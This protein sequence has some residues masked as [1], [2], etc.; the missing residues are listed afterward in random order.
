[1]FP[2]AV[3]IAGAPAQAADWPALVDALVADADLAARQARLTEALLASAADPDGAAR[4]ASATR[5]V[6]AL[7][8]TER[9]DR[10]VVRAFLVAALG[11]D[12]AVRA[13]AVEQAT[14]GGDPP[15]MVALPMP[16]AVPVVAPAPPPESDPVALRAYA[17]DRLFRDRLDMSYTDV[18]IAQGA[19]WANDI[20]VNTW[21]V[22]D[23]G[24]NLYGARGFAQKVGDGA[25]LVGLHRR[26]HK[27]LGGSWASIAGGAA[28]STTGFVLMSTSARSPNFEG[29]LYG[30]ATAAIVGSIPLAVG[31]AFLQ[32]ELRFGDLVSRRYDED[33]TDAWI[34]RYNR[35]LQLKL[36]LSDA[37]ALDI[38]L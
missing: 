22:Y 15:G 34:E 30:G 6:L 18:Y 14:A 2:L 20:H 37:D 33:A 7:A 24:G 5:V 38:D 27:V 9:S 13:Q 8:E 23:G 4:V 31:L 26:R 12:P 11:D 25:G 19:A 17:K 3:L 21:G 28:V 16:L 36:G 35:A 32:K 1:M 29:R 10:S